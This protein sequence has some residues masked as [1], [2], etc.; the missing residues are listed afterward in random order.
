[1][2]FNVGT[3]LLAKGP[4]RTTRFSSQS[5]QPIPKLPR[6]HPR[7][8]LERTT[9]A[10]GVGKPEQITDLA[11]RALRVTQVQQREVLAAFVEQRIEPAALIGQVPLQAAQAQ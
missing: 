7:P 8:A 6:C 10:A 1:M 11:Q 3:S 9:E 2:H 4:A 5:P